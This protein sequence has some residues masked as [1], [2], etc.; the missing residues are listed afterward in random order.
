MNFIDPNLGNYTVAA[1]K[2]IPKINNAVIPVIPRNSQVNNTMTLYHS[3]V[4]F[5]DRKK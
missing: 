3:A 1:V 5:L 2:T 4:Y